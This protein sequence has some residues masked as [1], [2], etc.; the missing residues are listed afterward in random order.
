MEQI[1]RE[2]AAKPAPPL[3]PRLAGAELV[4]A[5][6]VPEAGGGESEGA[7][8]VTAADLLGR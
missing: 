3:P 8:I 2:L 4:R 7:M 5:L 6:F 1:L